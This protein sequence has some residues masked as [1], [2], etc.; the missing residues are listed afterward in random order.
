M[1]E[2]KIKSDHIKEKVSRHK[3]SIPIEKIKMASIFYEKM[4]I[5]Y[6]DSFYQMYGFPFLTNPRFKRVAWAIDNF[7]DE[8]Y[9]VSTLWFVEQALSGGPLKKIVPLPEFEAIMD[10]AAHIRKKNIEEQTP[11]DSNDSEEQEKPEPDKFDPTAPLRE[12]YKP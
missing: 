8:D 11:D 7:F 1:S 6:G 12:N 9:E 2:D 3:G 4:E 10:S 5:I